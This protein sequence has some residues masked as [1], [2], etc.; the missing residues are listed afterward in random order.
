MKSIVLTGGGTAGH[1]TPHFAI[2][3]YLEGF[4]SVNY[5]GSYGG[6][7][8]NLVKS[9]NIPYYSVHAVKLIRPFTLKNLLIPFKFAKAVN[10]AKSLLKKLKPAVVFSKGGYVALPVTVAARE[11]KIPAVIHESDLTLGLS[12]KIASRYAEK[13]LTSFRPTA[14]TVKNG[15]FVGSPVREELFSVSREEC[16][17]K[18]GFSGKKPILL[19]TGGSS[20]AKSLNELFL[21]AAPEILKSYDVLHLT[22]KGNRTPLSDISYRQSEFADMKYAYNAADICVSRAGSNTAFELMSLKI[23]TLFI[24]LPKTSSRGDQIQNAEY[25]KNL[26]VCLY[27]KQD[28]MTPAIFS[29]RIKDL[30][31]NRFALKNNISK[32]DFTPANKKIARILNKY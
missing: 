7:E 17:K 5:L 10:E 20:G 26:G 12:N 9:K 30:Y 18:W 28:D 27:E 1:V 22:G 3:K 8:E 4:D 6:M 24:P 31:F 19:I 2:L 14:G 25:F 23:P 32:S 16:L 21:K 29:E 11:L 15:I 13:T